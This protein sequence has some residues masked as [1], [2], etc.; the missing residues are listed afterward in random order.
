MSVDRAITAIAE[1]LQRTENDDL[2]TALVKYPTDERASA[3]TL[4]AADM[5]TL[6]YTETEWETRVAEL[7]VASGL[8]V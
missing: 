7:V 5:S 8:S 6:I 4:H 3:F 1:I 2:R